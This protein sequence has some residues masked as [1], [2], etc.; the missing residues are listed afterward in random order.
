MSSIS[1]ST[2]YGGV[3]PLLARP[4][5]SWFSA[6]NWLASGS[7]VERVLNAPAVVVTGG[8]SPYRSNAITVPSAD[9]TVS[10]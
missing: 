3:S 1:R 4:R 5:R 10:I 9:A 6:V 7:A 8:P 2:A